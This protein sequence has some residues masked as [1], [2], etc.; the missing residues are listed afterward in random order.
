MREAGSS[1]RISSA[2]IRNI[3]LTAL[4]KP[5]DIVASGD[6]ADDRGLIRRMLEHLALTYGIGNINVAMDEVLASLERD[7]VHPCPGL[8]ILPGR[9]ERVSDP[10]IALSPIEKG[11]AI[12]G[13]TVHLLGIIL[14]P[15]D[16][17][18]AYQQ[19][20]QGIVR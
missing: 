4:F 3:R 13:E 17:P 20:R 5:E 16:M 15:P 12:A 9:L 14:T 2:T 19:I 18:G 8:A 7:D 11:M 6:A 1:R 10:L